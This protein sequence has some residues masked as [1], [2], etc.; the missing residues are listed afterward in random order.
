MGQVRAGRGHSAYHQSLVYLPNRVLNQNGRLRVQRRRVKKERGC[1]TQDMEVKLL[2]LL[3][4]IQ[5]D[6]M[7]LNGGLFKVGKS[8]FTVLKAW[9]LSAMG[10]HLSGM[11]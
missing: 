1:C 5:V 3:F 8:L 4:V 10:S 2:L 7:E 11:A 9:A 6:E